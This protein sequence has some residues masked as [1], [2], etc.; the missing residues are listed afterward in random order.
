MD[1]NHNGGMGRQELSE[2]AHE[3]WRCD[4]IC[5]D[6]QFVQPL[7][8]FGMSIREMLKTLFNRLFIDPDPF[9]SLE[10]LRQRRLGIDFIS[11][12]SRDIEQRHLCFQRINV[13]M[14]DLC[15]LG[16]FIVSWNPGDVGVDNKDDVC[17]CQSRRLSTSIPLAALM[18][19]MGCREV[20]G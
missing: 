8:A 12:L 9:Q 15:A 1:L 18:S 10:D 13:E 7:N 16:G 20:H 5:R 3:N 6:L 14:E 17:F 4:R 19:W 11:P 2:V